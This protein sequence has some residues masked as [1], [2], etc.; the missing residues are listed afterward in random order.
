MLGRSLPNGVMFNA[1]PDSIGTKLSDS[2]ALMQRPELHDVFSLFYI[3][4]TFFQSD[5]DRGFFHKPL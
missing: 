2:I 1:Y 5:L 3:L 4:P